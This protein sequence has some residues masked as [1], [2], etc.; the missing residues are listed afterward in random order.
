MAPSYLSN[1]QVGYS[2]YAIFTGCL[3]FD[4]VMNIRYSCS[5]IINVSALKIEFTQILS[6][7]PFVNF[8]TLALV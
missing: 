4:M 3:V 5:P 1:T 2:T 7:L 8:L 6:N